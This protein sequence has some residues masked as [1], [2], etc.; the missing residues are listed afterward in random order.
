MRRKHEL[1]IGAIDGLPCDLKRDRTEHRHISIISFYC[2][3]KMQ[4]LNAQE[5]GGNKQI[6]E[7]RDN[8]RFVNCRHKGRLLYQTTSHLRPA[9]CR[10]ATY[11]RRVICPRDGGGTAKIVAQ[12]Y[13]Q[14]SII[15][16][17]AVDFTF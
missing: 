12:Q 11:S 15:V 5:K 9:A 6:G 13:H 7:D 4:R 10:R 14:N 8:L 1:R 17:A 3:A 2:W 16:D